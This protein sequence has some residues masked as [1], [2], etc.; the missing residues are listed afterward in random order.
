VHADTSWLRTSDGVRLFAFSSGSGSTGVVLAHE[1]PGGVCGW[2]PAVSNFTANGVRVLAFDFR[3]FPPSAVPPS[4]KLDD[5]APDLQAAVDALHADGAKKVFVVGASFGGAAALSEGAKLHGVAGFVSLS[6]EL[7]LPAS[8]IDALGHV[9]RLRA[10]L[11]VLA[12]RKDYFLTGAAARQLVHA[13]GS[14]DK[15]LTVYPGFYHG[16]DLLERAPFARRVWSRLLGW[17]AAH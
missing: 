9:P 14:A 7:G 17:V 13:A 4:G 6:G 10:P 1:S 3:G 5:F 12:S 8:G 16:W 2:L 11:L 15:Q